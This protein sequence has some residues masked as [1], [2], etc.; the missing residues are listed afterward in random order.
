MVA[1]KKTQYLI[2][3]NSAGGIGA[4][5]AIRELDTKGTVTIISDEPY[6]VYS[7]PLISEYLAD[8][9]PVE[10]IVYRKPDFYEKNNIQALLGVKVT[11]VNPG[12]RTVALDDGK[13][14]AWRKLLL[15][16]GGTPILPNM[17]GSQLRGVFT[18]N[19]LDDA[20]AI[21][22]FL[23][24]HRRKVKAVVIGG[25]LIGTSVAD[26]LTR[27]GADVVI[28][29]MKDRVLNTI[30]D[31][32]ASAMEAKAL[33]GAGITIITGHTVRDINSNLPGEVSSVTLD[34]EHL[35]H[36]EMVIVAIGVRPRLELAAGS[37]IRTNRGIIVDRHMATSLPDIYAC[38]DV[39]EA[40]DFVIGENR[41]TPIWPNAYEG[42]RTAGLNM[43]GR[44]TGYPGG[45]I[46]N[47]MK[48]FGVNIVSAGLVVPPDDSY[49]TVSHRSNG[50]YRKIVIKDGKL[51][52]LVFAGEIEKSGIVYNLMKEG[53][54]VSGFKEALVADDFGLASLP[55]AI[56]REY[57]AQPEAAAAK[58]VT[59]AVPPEESMMGD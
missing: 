17:E 41:L 55:S 5:E 16:T 32:E 19:R 56:W 10:K 11:Q 20:K 6:P 29:E 38:G 9:C 37:G 35:I 46:M 30:L 34:D 7:R 44:P 18:F 43:A 28:V 47:A 13:T 49:E 3:G 22:E 48:Y 53:R 54:D 45:T 1:I 57:L 26:A 27:R 21:D 39:A 8:P 31:E 2:I 4:A 33:E 58:L 52:G 14:I 42:G 50:I 59:I 15:A 51:V 12:G 24:R 40:Y 25:G 23:S 36:C